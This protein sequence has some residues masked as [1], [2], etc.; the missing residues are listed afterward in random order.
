VLDV[1]TG[2]ADVAIA[3]ATM[4]K[5][6]AGGAALATDAVVG[7]DPRYSLKR[8]H[9]A[10]NHYAAYHTSTIP[11]NPMP[12]RHAQGSYGSIRPLDSPNVGHL[13]VHL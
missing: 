13:A 2:T 8:R 6:K 10:A 1:G 9:A 7:V 11:N 5:K 3:V 4:L 12:A